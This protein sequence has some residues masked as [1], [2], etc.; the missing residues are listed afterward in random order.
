MITHGDVL[1]QKG[2]AI[3]ALLE[4]IPLRDAMFVMGWTSGQVLA[5]CQL[6]PGVTQNDLIN[7]FNELVRGASNL[8]AFETATETNAI[9]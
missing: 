8:A 7:H 5:Q 9:N 4:G 6:G 2:E 1:Y 3:M